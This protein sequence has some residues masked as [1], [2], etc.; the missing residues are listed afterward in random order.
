VRPF[1]LFNA[2]LGG[3]PSTANGNDYGPVQRLPAVSGQFTGGVN[4]KAKIIAFS[5]HSS[6]EYVVRM[7]RCGVH[8][9][10]MKDQPAAE[11]LDAIK[12]VVRGGLHFPADMSDALSRARKLG[13]SDSRSSRSAPPVFA[14]AS[15]LP[16][17][18]IATSAAL[19]AARGFDVPPSQAKTD[20]ALTPPESLP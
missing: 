3:L 2:N 12:H 14:E 16:N 18:R 15:R 11:L 8:G 1:P 6:E 20:S 17:L 4:T 9:Y 10:V 5:V 7:A 19:A 13:P